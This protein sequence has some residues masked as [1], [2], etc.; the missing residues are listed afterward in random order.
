MYTC[1]NTYEGS[2][3]RLY[4]SIEEVRRD[5]SRIRRDISETEEMLSVNNI[6]ME[7]IPLWAERSPEEWIPELENAV[8]V[9]NDGLADLRRLKEGLEILREELDDIRCMIRI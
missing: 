8:A 3:P 4:R 1:M 6:L 7:M 5:I 9:A 2:P